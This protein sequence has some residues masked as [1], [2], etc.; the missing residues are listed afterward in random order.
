MGN[1]QELNDKINNF[2]TRKTQ[3]YPEIDA[4][5]EKLIR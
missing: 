1:K 3:K 5:V 2:L 4:T